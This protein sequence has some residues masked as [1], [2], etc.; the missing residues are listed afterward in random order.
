MA[1]YY[2]E[3][4]SELM[5]QWANVILE[6]ESPWT[7]FLF[8][9]HYDVIPCIYGD[10]FGGD[11][12]DHATGVKIGQKIGKLKEL[13]SVTLKHG[14]PSLKKYFQNYKQNYG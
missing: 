11:R 10:R 9:A 14:T 4:Y 8:L 2:F 6:E 5:P 3:N 13:Q 7:T 1:H 12:S